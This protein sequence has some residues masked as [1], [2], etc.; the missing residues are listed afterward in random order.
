[1]NLYNKYK[2]FKILEFYSRAEGN[3]NTARITASLCHHRYYTQREAC[4]PLA[5]QVDAQA[6]RYTQLICIIVI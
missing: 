3:F 1:M 2:L 4:R 5:Q 6:K